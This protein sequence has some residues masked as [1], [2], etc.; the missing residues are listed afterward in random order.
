[1][2]KSKPSKTTNKET[3]TYYID[4]TNVCYWQDS[5][6]PSLNVLLKLLITLKRDKKQSF[7]CIFDANTMHILSKDERNIY[8]A[9]LEYKNHF[10]Q[11]SGGKRADDYILGLADMYDAPVISNDTYSDPKYAKYKWKER[12]YRP[13]RLFMGE[14]IKTPKGQHLML[15]DLDVNI[16]LKSSLEESYK[17]LELILNPPETHYKGTV[18]FFIQNKGWGR[19]TYFKEESIYFKHN[20]DKEIWQAGQGVEFT[21]KQSE[22]GTYADN[23]VAVDTLCQ[24]TITQ[25]DNEKLCGFI[26]LNNTDKKLFFYKSYFDE[27]PTKALKVNQQVTFI[28]GQNNKGACARN[29]KLTSQTKLLNKA[30][31]SSTGVADKELVKKFSEKEEELNAT[32][33]NLQ[34]KLKSYESLLR[35][36][37]KKIEEKRQTIKRLREESKGNPKKEENKLLKPP[38]PNKEKAKEK[39]VVQ[40]KQNS[41]EKPKSQPKQESKSTNTIAKAKENGSKQKEDRSTVTTNQPK[42]KAPKKPPVKKEVSRKQSNSNNGHQ[43]GTVIPKE[44]EQP[45]EKVA[46]KPAQKTTVTKHIKASELATVPVKTSKS[47]KRPVHGG[48]RKTTSTKAEEAKKRRGYK[49]NTAKKRAAWW[50]KL[51]AQW[52]KAFNV[53]LTGEEVIVMPSDEKILKLFRIKRLSFYYT[54]KTRLSFRLTNLSGLRDLTRLSTLNV[55]NHKLVDLKGTEELHNLRYFNC[56]RNNLKSLQGIKHLSSLKQFL[57]AHNNLSVKD[58]QNL[59]DKI[60][61]LESLDCRYNNLSD[62]DKEKIKSMKIDNILL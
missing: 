14:V 24:G 31:L 39:E 61:G 6:T 36:A 55:A 16:L 38:I 26:N 21:V 48:G 60:D 47:R 40:A 50:K 34:S 11:V 42:T 45:K 56:S 57:C 9:L 41:V 46:A 53:V 58:L 62:E 5:N 59:N 43:S 22:K 2:S 28:L 20:N 25:Y 13:I 19:I 15:F 7:Y 18:K 4:A 37:G 52:K 17:T 12:I 35:E 49:H 30:P 27:E 51:E 1:M 33:K 32:I 23:L 44:K 3:I 8:S 29:I 10:H 54:S